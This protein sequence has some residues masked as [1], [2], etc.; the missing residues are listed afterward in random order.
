[1]AHEKIDDLNRLVQI[2]QEAEA[3]LLTAAEDSRNSELETLFRGY[4]A[5]HA[6]FRGELQEELERLD[7]RS[8]HEEG[9]AEAVRRAW[10]GVTSAFSGHAADSLLRS[11]ESCE[12]SAEV[13][14]ADAGDRNPSGRA[15]ALIEKHGQQIRE[16]RAHLHR[17]V[18]ETKHGTT[19]QNNEQS[20]V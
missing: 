2:N 5:Q 18:D 15:H 8:E 19:F 20:G 4:A 12:E 3:T 7:D 9:V 14:Y 13:A 10:A 1:M 16:F 11:C 6:K 17:L